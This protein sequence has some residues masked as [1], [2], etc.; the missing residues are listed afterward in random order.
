MDEAEQL[1][2]KSPKWQR[3]LKLNTADCLP[4][5]KQAFLSTQCKGTT[6]VLPLHAFQQH[7]KARARYRHN[8]E[9]GRNLCCPTE[10][11]L[12]NT[13]DTPLG[14]ADLLQRFQPLWLPHGENQ[15][16]LETTKEDNPLYFIALSS[17]AHEINHNLA[18]SSWCSSA[19]L[20]Y[21]VGSYLHVESAEE[22][23]MYV[24]LS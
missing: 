10:G 19:I 1:F 7:E 11:A 17:E 16:G 8:R 2:L 20:P 14:C 12:L 13:R 3:M 15:L 4:G 23:S 18:Y 22:L 21:K 24:S 9:G 5:S 6:G